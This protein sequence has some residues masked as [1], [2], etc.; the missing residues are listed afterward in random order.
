[1]TA[2]LR[3]PAVGQR[4]ATVVFI[5]GLGQT[6]DSWRSMIEW[7][8]RQLPRVEWVLP[9]ASS[10]PVA[11]SAGQL[12]PSWFNIAALPPGDAEWDEAGVAASAAYIESIIQ[13]EVQA[14]ADPRRIVVAGFSQGGAL[15]L[16]VA[17]TSLHDLGGAASF[18]GWVPHRGREHIMHVHTEPTLPVFLGHGRQDT[19]IPPYY[20]EESIAFLRDVLRLRNLEVRRYERLGHAVFGGEMYDFVNWLLRVLHLSPVIN[21]A[22]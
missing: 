20:A 11:V 6:N 19:E 18:S 3:F 12:R 4:L 9:Q 15:G 14:G 2:L 16:L 8:A 7:L 22:P 17:L 10:R 1:M 13:G 5:H 21:G